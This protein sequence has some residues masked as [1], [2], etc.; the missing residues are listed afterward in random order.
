MAS[1]ICVI[2]C[3]Y[4]FVSFS[5]TGMPSCCFRTLAGSQ[6]GGIGIIGVCMGQGEAITT[7]SSQQ[8]KSWL[9]PT[10]SEEQRSATCMYAFCGSWWCRAYIYLEVG[11]CVEP[12]IKLPY[13]LAGLVRPDCAPAFGRQ[14]LSK[15]NIGVPQAYNDIVPFQAYQQARRAPGVVEH[16]RL[17]QVRICWWLRDQFG[18]RRQVQVKLHPLQIR[19]IEA[20]SE[21]A[22]LIAV[23][24]AQLPS[25][26]QV[27]AVLLLVNSSTLH[28]RQVCIRLTC[29]AAPMDQAYI[30]R[31]QPSLSFVSLSSSMCFVSRS[32][33]GV[34]CSVCNVPSGAAWMKVRLCCGLVQG[35]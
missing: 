14:A 12:L 11:V 21:V 35:T 2:I 3:S 31:T 8:K 15:F 23:P 6:D 18:R 24:G 5:V 7:K 9:L 26:T 34:I 1:F 10:M 32:Q 13:L 27:V 28:S 29:N 22:I 16:R 20:H 30:S 17:A 33:S 19:A 25:M 4:T